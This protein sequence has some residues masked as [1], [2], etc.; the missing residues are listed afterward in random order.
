MSKKIKIPQRDPG[1]AYV[2]EV[3][4]MRKV[5][6]NARCACGEDRPEALIAGRDPMICFACERVKNGR[7]TLDDH[8]FAGRA[9]SDITLPVPVNDHRSLSSAQHDWPKET[10]ENRD[11]SPLLAGAACVRGVVDTVI[12][13]VRRGLLWIAE[14]LEWLHDYLVEKLGPKWWLGKPLELLVPKG[15]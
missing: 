1:A 15:R 5:G 8:H 6:E 14:L 10:L 9:N 3:K 7:T 4:R 11:G 2:R 13:L 12:D